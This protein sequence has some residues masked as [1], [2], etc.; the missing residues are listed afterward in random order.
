MGEVDRPTVLV[1]D[2][3]EDVRDLVAFRLERSGYRVITAGDG[4]E[5]L[6]AIRERTP[7]LAVLDVMMPRMTGYEVTRALRGDEAT[8]DIPVILLTARVHRSELADGLEAGADAYVKKPFGAEELRSRIAAVL[9]R[10]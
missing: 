6:R 9:N 1:A 4:A 10:R 3:D 8:R 7:A 5:A 2:D